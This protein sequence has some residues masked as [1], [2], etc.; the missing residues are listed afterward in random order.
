[1]LQNSSDSCSRPW[2]AV[3]P[4]RSDG[5]DHST[6]IFAGRRVRQAES[7]AGAMWSA[8]QEEYITAFGACVVAGSLGHSNRLKHP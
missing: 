7:D 5:L 2:E 3:D 1:M 8:P 4:G 6:S